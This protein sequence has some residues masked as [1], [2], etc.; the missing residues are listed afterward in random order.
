MSALPLSVRKQY[1]RSLTRQDVIP[2][3][4]LYPHIVEELRAALRDAL[5]EIPEIP[6]REQPHYKGYDGKPLGG[7]AC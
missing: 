4:R 7:T 6:C 5:Q 1:W 2:Y 3:L